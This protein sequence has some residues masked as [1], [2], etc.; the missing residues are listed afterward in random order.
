MNDDARAWIEAERGPVTA[1]EPLRGGAGRRRYW[2]VRHPDHPDGGTS[3]LVHAAPEDP[4]ILPP[5]LRADVELP[6]HDSPFVRITRLLEAN[7]IPVPRI[8]ALDDK[9]DWMLL[10]DLGERHLLDLG[11]TERQTRCLELVELLA[12]VHAIAECDA[13]PFRRAFDA[14]WVGFELRLFL[15]RVSDPRLREELAGAFDAL[16]SAIA[17]LPRVLCLRDVQSQNVMIDARGALRLIDYQ[18]ALL[19][20]REL[21]LAALLHDSYVERED[22]EREALLARYAEASGTERDRHAFAL[23]VA[24]RKCK[25]LSRFELLLERGDARYAVPRERA[26]RSIRHALPELPLAGLA[27]LLERALSGLAA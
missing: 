3:V 1:L 13:L 14:E 22:A 7:A 20:P 6:L 18:D 19:A 24:Q 12:R 26:A 8:H 11:A 23:L 27:P 17:A 25:D 4:S 15:E 16:A 2:R 21:D 5:A 10:E 9:R